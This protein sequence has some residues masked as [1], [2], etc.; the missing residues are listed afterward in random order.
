M[1]VWTEILPSKGY[2]ARRRVWLYCHPIPHSR[3]MF[4]YSREHV[5]ISS[6]APIFSR[7][8]IGGEWIRPMRILSYH[9]QPFQIHSSCRVKAWGHTTSQADHVLL[10]SRRESEISST[11]GRRRTGLEEDVERGE[12]GHHD[13]YSLE[14]YP[15]WALKDGL[16]ER[17]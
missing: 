6:P 15:K 4:Q 2:I 9:P 10:P 7:V 1:V 14:N 3:T 5:P 16:A 17:E 8:S 11:E 13:G 12:T